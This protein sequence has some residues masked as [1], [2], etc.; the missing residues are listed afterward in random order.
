MKKIYL[1][2]AVAIIG[3]ST[4]TPVTA[5]LVADLPNMQVLFIVSAIAF[6]S[7][8]LLNCKRENWQ[9]LR[10]YKLKDIVAQA[11]L[12]FLGL[13][14]YT[15]LYNFGLTQLSAQDANIINYLWPLMIILFSIP[16]L[17]EK[18]TFR[19]ILAATLSF[20]GLIVIV[21]RGD[22]S[23]FQ[24]ESIAGIAACFGAAVCFGLFS[25]LNK[26]ANYNQFVAIVI[27]FATTMIF[28]GIAF[29]VGGNFAP[30]TLAQFG[31]LA[32][33]GIMSNA[34]AYLAW[35]I[36]LRRGDTAKISNSAY[37]IPFLTV[38]LSALMLGE[39][40]Y[41]YSIIGLLLIVGGILIQNLKLK[42]SPHI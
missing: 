21:T 36:A 37:I 1:L 6:V 12:G 41:I 2:V 13:F 17:R 33:L 11:G 8:L 3:W 30:L 28:S 19:K 23:S 40:I 39:N 4:L 20:I 42:K 27:F 15:T 25:V 24:P 38:I 22:I 7:A 26:K 32:W 16:I 9:I 35:G 5:L 31:G 29:A 14:L 10:N 18:L 34:V